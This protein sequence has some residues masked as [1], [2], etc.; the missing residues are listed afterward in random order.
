M[1]YLLDTCVISELVKKRPESAVT[2]WIRRQDEQ[3]LYLCV[4]S[5]G[6][7]QKGIVKLRDPKRRDKL[8]KWLDNDL[9]R[10]F[11]DRILDI[12]QSVAL[13]WGRLQGQAEDSG[14][15]MAV[16]DGLIAAA[17]ICSDAFVVTRNEEDFEP[18]GVRIINPW[19]KA[20]EDNR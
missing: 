5:L 12:S 6:E 11:S 15:K 17:A 18:S 16:I 2:D 1:N 20:S 7:I 10:R 14:R 4:L 8:R 13:T 19:P 9:R 3:T